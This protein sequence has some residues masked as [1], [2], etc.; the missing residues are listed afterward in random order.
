[1]QITLEKADVSERRKI[2]ELYKNSFPPEERA[3]YFLLERMT[4]NDRGRMLAA[5]EGG[6]FV[7]FVYLVCY[8]DMVYLF[9]F[10][11]EADKRGQNY[12]SRILKVLQEKYRGKRLFLAREQLDPA[13]DNYRQRVKRHEFYLK[14]GFKDWTCKIKEASVVYD[15]MGIGREISAKEYEDLITGWCGKLFRKLADMRVV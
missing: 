8:S 10:A 5:R 9:Y 13:A 4:K 7:G 12:G 14:N 3:P 6:T 2:K 1:M 15:V 11:V